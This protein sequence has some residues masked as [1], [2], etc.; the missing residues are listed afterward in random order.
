V[1][2][3]RASVSSPLALLGME[4]LYAKSDLSSAVSLSPIIVEPLLGVGEW[5]LSSGV[6]C[7][8]PAA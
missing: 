3:T 4:V 5:D 7:L 1:S 6:D 2:W 8:D